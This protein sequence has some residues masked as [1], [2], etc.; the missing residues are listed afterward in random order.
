VDAELI[1]FDE[2]PVFPESYDAL[3]AAGVKMYT[4]VDVVEEEVN[5]N[6]CVVHYIRRI[7]HFPKNQLKKFL[8]L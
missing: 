4:V 8:Y 2:G 5:A 7:I 6:V 1:G 3:E